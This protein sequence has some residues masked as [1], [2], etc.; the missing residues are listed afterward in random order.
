MLGPTTLAYLAPG[1]FRPSSGPA[2]EQLPVDHADL[3]VLENLCSAEER[4]EAGINE[5][6]SP[7]FCVRDGGDVVAAA[8]YVTWPRKTAHVAVLTAPRARGRGLAKVTASGAVAHA[9]AAGMLPQWRA[10]VP[11]SQQV[12]RTLGFVELGIQ[13][14]LELA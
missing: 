11:A 5:L 6:T 9:L 4:N 14:S 3:R 10:R 2:V 12:A 8:G 13:I 1:S 7:V